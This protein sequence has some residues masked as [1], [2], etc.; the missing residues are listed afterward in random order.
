MRLAYWYW[1]ELV[2]AELAEPPYACCPISGNTYAFRLVFS[3]SN[4]RV[5]YY[6]QSSVE[7]VLPDGHVACLSACDASSLAEAYLFRFDAGGYL[8][9]DEARSAGEQLRQALLVADLLHGLGLAIS[10]EDLGPP[11]T[12]TALSEPQDRNSL[13]QANVVGLWI[14]KEEWRLPDL[15]GG[16]EAY[17][18][19]VDPGYIVESINLVWN[20]V[21]HFGKK[22]QPAVEL[23][24][25]SMHESSLR[26]R[27]LLSYAA[28]QT[29]VPQSKRSPET[30]KHIKELQQQ[31]E[32]SCLPK[33]EKENLKTS[34]GNLERESPATAIK[35]FFSKISGLPNIENEEPVDFLLRCQKT[36]NQLSHPAAPD[37]PPDIH[38][39]IDGLRSIASYIILFESGLLPL[40][41]PGMSEKLMFN[42]LLSN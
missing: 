8:N 26:A 18:V 35:K 27:F 2:L 25:S 29:L 30:L 36:R 6:D 9:Y 10:Y 5:F 14:Y 31:V 21:H 12:F 41:L 28:L 32:R 20:S 17:P 3:A 1:S 38:L 42:F 40:E 39:M 4:P 34:L 22:S 7:N 33:I 13:I 19:P 11:D 23:L 24:R 16:G 15:T 37:L